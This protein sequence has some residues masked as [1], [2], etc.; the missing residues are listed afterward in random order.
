MLPGRGLLEQM[1]TVRGS[2]GLGAAGGVQLAMKAVVRSASEE[3]GWSQVP[4]GRSEIARGSWTR[5]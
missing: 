4:A 1:G 3:E 2:S 5:R